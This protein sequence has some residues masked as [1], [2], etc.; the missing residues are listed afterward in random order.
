MNLLRFIWWLFAH[1]REAEKTII[2]AG[3]WAARELAEMKRREHDITVGEATEW[4]KDVRAK[5]G[6]E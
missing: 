1:P 4:A 5:L 6:K 3:E 2:E